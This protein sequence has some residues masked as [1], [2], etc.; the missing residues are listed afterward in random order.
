MFLASLFLQ[1]FFG[2]ACVDV[3]CFMYVFYFLVLGG[4]IFLSL[5][6]SVVNHDGFYYLT[7]LAIYIYIYIH[8][9]SLVIDVY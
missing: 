9:I 8:T 2:I 1:V 4:Y 6:N 5:L 3:V 7:N